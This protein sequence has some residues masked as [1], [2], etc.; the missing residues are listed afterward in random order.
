MLTVILSAVP[1]DELFSS[2]L[3]LCL[4]AADGPEP[5]CVL[6]A[7]PLASALL[8]PEGAAILKARQQLGQLELFGVRTCSLSEELPA[9]LPFVQQLTPAA[10][11]E[12]LQASRVMLTF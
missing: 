12:L 8:Q 1:P 3:A 2:G 9:L 5:L 7:E 11:Q 10:G 6:L 4:D